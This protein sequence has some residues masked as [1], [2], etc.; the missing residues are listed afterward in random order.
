A[1]PGKYAA[2]AVKEQMGSV[3]ATDS[4]GIQRYFNDARIGKV[5]DVVK[6]K[7]NG[8]WSDFTRTTLPGNICSQNLHDQVTDESWKWKWNAELTV[9]AEGGS[10]S[11]DQGGH[12]HLNPGDWIKAVNNYGWSQKLFDPQKI[13]LSSTLT[14]D[15]HI[16]HA[17]F[18]AKLFGEVWC[19]FE[20]YEDP[21]TREWTNGG[22]FGGMTVVAL[23][24]C[25]F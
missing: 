22:Q 16:G 17:L 4:N 7:I 3:Q 11:V 5:A 18:K 1:A 23:L 10:I 13:S 15:G 2:E 14:G 21:E 8:A 24:E 6:E 9:A 12:P 20:G 19:S 25:W